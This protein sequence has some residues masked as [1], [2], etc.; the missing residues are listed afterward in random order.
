M[1]QVKSQRRRQPNHLTKFR[2]S[3]R[4]RWSFQLSNKNARTHHYQCRA[5]GASHGIWNPGSAQEEPQRSERCWG[6]HSPAGITT[7]FIKVLENEG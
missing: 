2:E 3:V 7:S 4:R 5:E 6:S 1:N